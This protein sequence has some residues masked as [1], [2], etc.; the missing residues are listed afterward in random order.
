MDESEYRIGSITFCSKCRQL[1]ECGFV[2]TGQG[3][4]QSH[5]KY[6]VQAPTSM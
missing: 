6:R 4:L 3:K 5:G 1:S 2:I